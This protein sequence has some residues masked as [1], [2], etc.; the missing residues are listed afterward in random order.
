[1]KQLFTLF[2]LVGTLNAFTQKYQALPT[3]V[4]VPSQSSSRAVADTVV[5]TVNGGPKLYI[6]FDPISLA[7]DT[8]IGGMFAGTDHVWTAISYPP[9]PGSIN[10]EIVQIF[11][12]DHK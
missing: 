10:K 4:K 2:A 1:M 12:T 11:K 9:Q 8:I 3:D 5:W 7:P 6:I